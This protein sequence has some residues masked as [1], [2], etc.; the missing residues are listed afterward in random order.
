MKAFVVWAKYYI[1]IGSNVCIVIQLSVYLC[2]SPPKSPSPRWDG[3]LHSVWKLRSYFDFPC[4][5][6]EKWYSTWFMTLRGHLFSAPGTLIFPLIGVVCVYLCIFVSY[7]HNER[8]VQAGFALQLYHFL[9]EPPR[10]LLGTLKTTTKSQLIHKPNCNSLTLAS[11]DTSSSILL[12]LFV[13]WFLF[14]ALLADVMEKGMRLFG[15]FFN[16]LPMYSV[17]YTTE[18][19]SQIPVLAVQDCSLL[20][21]SKRHSNTAVFALPL[22]CFLKIY[23]WNRNHNLSIYNSRLYY[24]IFF[25]YINSFCITP[26]SPI[27]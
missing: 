20:M 5:I 1:H 7:L 24:I 6:V 14:C 2:S 19:I 11:F 22:V 8:S 16:W 12:G 17:T 23:N 13:L 25:L 21:G 27:D 4:R 18:A 3:Y 10:L 15:E 26:K 9:A